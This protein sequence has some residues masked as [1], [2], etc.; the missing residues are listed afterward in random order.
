[1]DDHEV[2][3]ETDLD[4]PTAGSSST[5]KRLK[6]NTS[7]G[8]KKMK[9]HMKVQVARKKSENSDSTALIQLTFSMNTSRQYTAN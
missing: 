6:G 3:Y 4:R 5:R 2:N 1:M 7:R 8:G 9:L